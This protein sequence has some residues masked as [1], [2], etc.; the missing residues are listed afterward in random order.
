M[1]S[2]NAGYQSDTHQ[3]GEV[4]NEEA[5]ISVGYM[6]TIPPIV[7]NGEADMPVGYMTTIPPILPPR[8]IDND[9]SV[10][11]S[12]D[13]Q[14]SPRGSYVDLTNLNRPKEHTYQALKEGPRRPPLYMSEDG[15]VVNVPPAYLDIY[16]NP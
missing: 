3:T 13:P 6:T 9:G 14:S 10:Y 8:P 7:T 16:P 12:L 2:N 11:D 4:T 15:N 1:A 5:D